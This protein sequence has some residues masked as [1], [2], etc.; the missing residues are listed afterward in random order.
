MTRSA[1]LP[2]IKSLALALAAIF[3][4]LAACSCAQQSFVP[5]MPYGLCISEVVSS[6]ATSLKDPEVGT[7]DWIE[8]YNGS[9][10]AIS[11]KGYGLSDNIREPHKWVF[12]DV[13]IE[14]GEYLIVY[15][16]SYDKQEGDGIMLATGFGLSKSG[17]VLLLTDAYYNIIQQLTVP[18]LRQDISYALGGDG[19]YG[20]C[21]IPTPGEANSQ[22]I[23]SNIA[24]L[25]RAGSDGALILSEVV[26]DN[27]SGPVAEDGARYGWAEAYN[28]SDASV[29]LH[30]Y[31]LSDDPGNLTK[32]RLPDTALGAGEYLVIHLTGK[33]NSSDPLAASFKLSG[34]ETALYLSGKEQG[35]VSSL[36]WDTPLPGDIAVIA[37]ADEQKYTAFST[38]GEANSGAAFSSLS[39][40]S[41]DAG[42]PVRINE[43]LVENRYSAMDSDSDRPAWVELC[44]SSSS[45][46]PLKG[47]A[48]SDDPADPSKWPL[49]DVTLGAGEYLV[50]FLSGKDRTEG[51]L[52]ANFSLSSNDSSLTLTNLNGLRE[53]TIP[54]SPD[55]G[56]NI[57]IGRNEE[58]SLRYYAQPT[59]GAENAA[60][61]FETLSMITP[62]DTGGVFISEVR[63]VGEIKSNQRDYVELHNGSSAAV[64]LEGWFLSDDPDEPKLFTLPDL[65]IPAGGY[66]LVYASSDAS[67]Q[68]QSGVTAPFGISASGETLLLTRPDGVTVDAFSTGALR[69][70]ITS[71]RDASD[72]SGARRFYDDPTPGAANAA[73][74]YSGYAAAPALSNASLYQSAPF[75]LTISVGDPSARIYYTTDGS[76]PS[77][78]STPYTQ[79]ISI[80]KNTILRTAA[81]ADGRLWSDVVTKTYLFET[82]HTL[83]VVCLSGAPSAID[84]VYGVIDRWKKIEREG[85]MEYYEAGGTPGV[86]FPCGLRVNGASSLLMRQKS[87]SIYLR[88]GYGQSEVTY[89][90][91]EGNEIK[92]FRSLVVRNSGQDRTSARL[93]DS[94]CSLAVQ[95]LNIDNFATRPVIV[96]INAVYWG[97]YD[98]NE[99]QNEDY[100]AAHY[101]ADPDSVEIIRRNT[102]VLSGS[103][104]DFKRVRAY[105]LNRNLADDSVY[106]EFCQ[107]V[108]VDYF[109][110][111]LIAQTYFA[112][113]DMFNQKYWRSTDGKVKWRPVYYDLDFSLRG[114]APS[115]SILGAY[116]TYEGVPSQDG[117]LTNMDIFYGLKKN[118]SWRDQFC[119]RYVYVVVNQFSAE[120]LTAL[121]DQTAAALKPEMERHLERWGGI[122]SV[123]E[124]E[125]NVRALRDCLEKRPT[126]ALNSLKK[127]F[128]LTD[129]KMQAYLDAAS[130]GKSGS[131]F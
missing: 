69:S 46:V 102:T 49:P 34:T 19:K 84:Q 12:P 45:P 106:E 119:A 81:I 98:L 39:P 30:D 114:A 129:A 113:S 116:F 97:I 75:A 8:L 93:R 42:N 74:S 126:Y 89:P 130:A 88:A 1:R 23:V 60:A 28:A 26:P 70:G 4:A 120:R 40:V 109:T 48:L 41:M 20:F 87:L 51:E 35:S 90:F 122:S 57:S 101:G 99:N 24:E 103:N 61:G 9:D 16:A 80:G 2:R 27:R 10:R 121:L 117:T 63:A 58:G 112:N 13:S 85:Y 124:W 62:L 38:P 78:S 76:I 17:E 73:V 3:F 82:K 123:S 44:N 67:E 43:V 68:N 104:R 77:E 56:G 50:V 37:A 21:A 107:W 72:P 15:A 11:L 128:G 79:P 54:L 66:A 14:P 91:F 32:W 94:F 83:P 55:I 31:Y 115:R 7:P 95:G 52:H 118:A 100:L 65:S 29:Y 59:P 36:S 25:F 96:Y 108:D 105:A 110:D 18:T 33:D 125:S 127:Y 64:N 111:Y 6:N 71:G 47:Y 92:T 5:G 86:S 131:G 22:Q 53:D